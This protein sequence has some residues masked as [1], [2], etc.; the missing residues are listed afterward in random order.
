MISELD[1]WR[2]ASF[3]IRQR[4]SDAQLF[5]ALRADELLSAGD[6]TGQAVWLRVKHAI[7]ELQRA[8]PDPNQMV[9]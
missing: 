5:A 8:E 4:G 7:E 9:N 2:T 1:V 3:L 6:L